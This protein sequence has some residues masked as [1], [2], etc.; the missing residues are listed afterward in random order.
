MNRSLTRRLLLYFSVALLAFAVI[1]GGVFHFLFRRYASGLNAADL[2]NRAAAI[3]AMMTAPPSGPGSSPTETRSTAAGHDSGAVYEMRRRGQRHGRMTGE[4]GNHHDDSPAPAPSSPAPDSAANPSPHTYCRHRVTTADRQP[5]DRQRAN[6]AAEDTASLAAYL[7]HL[8]DLAASEVWLVDRATRTI[9]YYGDDESTSYEAL[10]PAAEAMLDRLFTGD[11]VTSGDFS[12]FLGTPSVTSGVPLKGG[13]DAITGALLLHRTLDDVQRSERD[14]IRLLALALGFAFLL[15]AGLSLLLARR[16][17]RPL[18]QMEA[19]AAALTDGR[20][21]TRTA[22]DRE[23]EI[24]SLARS[25]DTLA[26]RLA[27]ADAERSR[28]ARMRQDFLAGVS[29]ELRTPITVLK[30]SLELVASGMLTDETK[31]QDY[32]NQMKENIGALERLVGDLF[33]LTRLQNADFTIEKSPMNLPDALADAIRAAQRLAAAKDVVIERPESLSPIPIQGDYGRLRQMFL[34]VLDNAVKFSPEGGRIETS[35][36]PDEA[37][38]RVTIRDH[39]PGIDARD[40]PHIFERFHRQR[41][42]GN[43]SGT[44]LGLAI[45]REIARRHDIAIECQSIAGEGAAFLFS[46]SAANPPALEE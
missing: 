25:L 37:G 44:G 18:A 23:D 38:W 13:D 3:A 12:D 39:G 24:G 22:I 30:G 2:E 7:R 15:V 1:I 46:G 40:L 16:F 9:T 29:H 5:A 11:A 36:S 33:E 10:P 42:S 6:G 19:T 27:E 31:K 14:A 26:A 41:G 43:A 45:A 17:V 4:R 35:L 32:L 21:E 28:L 34:T 8:N 20:Y